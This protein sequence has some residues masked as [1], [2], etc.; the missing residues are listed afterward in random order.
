M[1]GTLTLSNDCECKTIPGDSKKKGYRMELTTTSA[2]GASLTNKFKVFAE[3]LN[4]T[5][6]RILLFI[7]SPVCQPK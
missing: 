4:S 7:C 6:K 5:K 3:L 1:V 2:K